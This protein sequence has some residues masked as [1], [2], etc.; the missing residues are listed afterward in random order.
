MEFQKLTNDELETVTGGKY[1]SYQIQPGDTLPGIAEYLGVSLST[2]MSL[3][4]IKNS[5]QVI[6]G[7]KLKYPC[8]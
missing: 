7:Q 4:G 3:N 5:D 2:L 8:R 6:V 1:G